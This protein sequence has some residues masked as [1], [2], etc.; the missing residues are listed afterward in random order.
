M[1]HFIFLE[2]VFSK[3]VLKSDL[4]LIALNDESVHRELLYLLK[5]KCIIAEH[6]RVDQ[7]DNDDLISLAP[8]GFVHIDLIKRVCFTWVLKGSACLREFCA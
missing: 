5:A 2:N 3:S 7:L 4:F 1:I 8:A 6:L